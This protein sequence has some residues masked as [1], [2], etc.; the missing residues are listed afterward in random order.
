MLKI[1]SD[2]NKV[3][4]LLQDLGNVTVYIK[5]GICESLEKFVEISTDTGTISL[6]CL[7]WDKT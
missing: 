4:L 5:V 3:A 1:T 2:L 6:F 7:Y